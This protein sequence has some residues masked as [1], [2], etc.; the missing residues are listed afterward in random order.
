MLQTASRYAV[1]HP[2]ET[3]RIEWPQGGSIQLLDDANRVA[4]TF[5]VPAGG[6]ELGPFPVGYHRLRGGGAT[7]GLSVVRPREAYVAGPSGVAIDTEFSRHRHALFPGAY[8]EFAAVIADTGLTTIRDRYSHKHI[9]P[10]RGQADWSDMV[11]AH[12]A[13]IANGITSLQV[14][15]NTPPWSRADLRDKAVPD[16]LDVYRR[17]ATDVADKLHGSAVAHE[18]WNEPDHQFFDELPDTLM[19]L[20][21]TAY[22]THKQRD[23]SVRITTP[24]FTNMSSQHPVKGRF[25]RLLFESGLAHYSDVFNM[26]QYGDTTDYPAAH[27]RF[28]AILEAHDA[29]GLPIWKTEFNH[30]LRPAAGRETPTFAQHLAHARFVSRAYP[31]MLSG[32]IDRA[33]LFFFDYAFKSGQIWFG[34]FDNGDPRGT[35]RRRPVG[36]PMPTVSALSNVRYALGRAD[37]VGGLTGLGEGVRAEVFD[38]GDGS[39]AVAVWRTPKRAWDLDP[40]PI[41]VELPIAVG[42]I[43]EALDFLG[44]PIEPGESRPAFAVDDGVVFVI[45]KPTA[46]LPDLIEPEARVVPPA[47]AME[48]YAFPGIVLRPRVDFDRVQ[49]SEWAYLVPAEG[50]RGVLDVHNY[51]TTVF[52]GTLTAEGASAYTVE[53]T[54]DPV[55]QLEPGERAEVPFVVRYTRREASWDV[56]RFVG[57]I[58]ETEATSPSVLGVLPDPRDF[59]ATDTLALDR[60]VADWVAEGHRS[61]SFTLQPGSEGGVRMEARYQPAGAGAWNQVFTR[62]NEPLDLS[63]YNAFRFEYRTRRGSRRADIQPGAPA[64]AEQAPPQSMNIGVRDG[65]GG[66][67]RL[68][69][70]FAGSY[71][72][73]PVTI[74]FSQL[75]SVPWNPDP[76]GDGL[77]MSQIRDVRVGGVVR[78]TPYFS[79]EFRNLRAVRL[80]EPADP[81]AG[82]F[83]HPLLQG[84]SAAQET[85]DGLAPE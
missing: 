3:V 41:T 76:A 58:G 85:S 46:S 59:D 56:V 13:L 25:F 55:L 57:R 30:A 24:S 49:R 45:L 65:S 12:D 2:D 22:L 39:R 19:A 15:H 21:K 60:P 44:R 9:E 40:E 67:Y 36:T 16:D 50:L 5:E 1:V 84:V 38:R 43:A 74:M 47:T 23:P 70:A 8:A 79:M 81:R 35:P 66:V 54:G 53:L 48:A 75:S 6:G 20:H 61:G 17:F 68:P 7:L 10:Q 77:D 26:H 4:E 42:E 37:Y 34:T 18:P 28:R 33:Y 64:D 72:W 78:T 82:F 62:F 63:A 29:A 69:T 27:A 71:D 32:G 11:R 73:K 14:A 51:G 52:A 83:T 80:P 31:A